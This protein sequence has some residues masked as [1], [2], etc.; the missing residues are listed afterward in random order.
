MHSLMILSAAAGGSGGA[1]IFM[2]MAP[3]LLIFVV[4]W[5][6]LIRPQQRRMREHAA[7]IAGAKRGDMVVTGGGLIGK[8]TKVDDTEV[9]IELAQGVK[10][11]AVKTTLS[12]V[13][14]PGGKPA[15][16]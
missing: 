16:D 15:N 4:F 7:K 13:L 3:L 14:A 1:A 11:R 9:E 8:V 2:Q 10:V 5:F 12:D 6:L